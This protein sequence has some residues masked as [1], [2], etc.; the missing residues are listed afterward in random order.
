[1]ILL[2][3]GE[4][5]DAD[6]Y[7]HS[8]VDIDH[9]FFLSDG[10]R[11]IL[12]VPKMNEAIARASFRGKVVVYKDAVEALSPFTKRKTV[13]FD[14]SSMSARMA[15]KIGKICRLKDDSQG[16]LK[17]RA[18][19]T[20]D[21]VSHIRRAVRETKD[22]FD[23]LDLESAKTELDL[24]KQLLSMTLER[25]L[26][27]AFEPIVAS[28]HNSSFPHYRAGMKKLGGLVLVD[29]GVR[30]RHY[31]A[32]LTRCFILDGDRK[33]KERYERLQGICHFL[34][35][36]LPSLGTGKDVA[37]LAEDLMAKAG[38]PK[39]IHSIG[40]GIGLDVHELPSLNRKSED[41][42]SKAAMAIEPAF[43]LKGYGMRYEETVWNDGK[44]AR[45]L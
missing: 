16:L 25:G 2:Y 29:Y 10:G 17:M 4:G 31:C 18:Q 32:D 41:P 36:S 12:F 30:Y 22:I 6:F 5:F 19:K 7:H 21:E 1:M 23:S 14:G 20:P 37:A 13:L 8:R 38:F 26:E 44:R 15:K 42:L 40:H 35:D 27:P 3:R 24:Q 39:M 28:G 9:C 11:R 33:K 45:V 34:A 43:Y